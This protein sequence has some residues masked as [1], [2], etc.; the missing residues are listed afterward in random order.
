MQIVLPEF[1]LIFWQLIVFLGLLFILSKY[2]WKPIAG[3]LKER[4][5]GIEKALQAAEAAKEE[6]A[7]LKATNEQL[8]IE[9]RKERE[10]ILADAQ[11]AANQIIAEAKEKAT[12]QANQIV[13]QAHASI[14][15]EKAATLADIKNQV[16][17]LSL[18]IAE[19][20]L[21]KELAEKKE[22]EVLATSF[23]QDIKL[24]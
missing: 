14:E 19:K 18:Q 13:A 15:R 20:I 17:V 5:E 7:K 21:R 9:A 24:N 12:V 16:A 10:K 23:L 6:M 1:G 4:E 8:L 3:M 11:N 2:A 22:Q